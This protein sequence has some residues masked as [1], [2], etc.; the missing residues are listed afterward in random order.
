MENEEHKTPFGPILGAEPPAEKP[1]KKPN[2][3]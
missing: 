1:V 3:K 2:K